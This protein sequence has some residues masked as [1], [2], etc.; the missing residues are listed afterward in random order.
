MPAIGQKKN[1]VNSTEDLAHGCFYIWLAGAKHKLKDSFIRA[2][3]RGVHVR[4]LADALGSRELVRSH[5]WRETGQDEAGGPPSRKSALD[6]SWRTVGPSESP[7]IVGPRRVVG[8]QNCADPEFGKYAPWVEEMS[9]WKK[10]PHYEYLFVSDWIAEGGD[11]HQQHRQE[12]TAKRVGIDHRASA[13]HGTDDRVRRDAA[14]F[15]ELIH[16]A[17]ERNWWSRRRIWC[18]MSSC[19]SRS[20]RLPVAASARRA[21]PQAQ[22]RLDRRSAQAAATTRT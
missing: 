10:A 20:P 5:H 19:F 3:R 4:L 2:A 8:D 22:R 15:A 11:R 16:S 14:C 17:R 18:R 13:R 6:H 9:R 12:S 1:K 7:E 21:V